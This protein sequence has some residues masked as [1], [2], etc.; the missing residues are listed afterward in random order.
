MSHGAVD[1]PLNYV[2]I[3]VT[4]A[5]L[6][7]PCLSPTFG[8]PYPLSDS[9]AKN[10]HSKHFEARVTIYLRSTLNISYQFFNPPPP[11]GTK[12]DINIS[13][14]KEDI[15]KSGL[16]TA[17]CA[18]Q[19]WMKWDSRILFP[20]NLHIYNHDYLPGCQKVFQIHYFSNFIK[21]HQKNFKTLWQ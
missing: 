11:V 3:L 12:E 7:P 9:V 5:T 8:L 6:S 14:A 15:G 19:I 17:Y 10:W 2:I 4:S 16:L 21:Y 1:S 20:M 13:I 18:V